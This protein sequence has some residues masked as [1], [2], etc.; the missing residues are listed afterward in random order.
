MAKR[1]LLFVFAYDVRKDS[2]RRK[3]S[4]RLERDL[5]RVQLSVFEGRMTKPEAE[6]LSLEVLALLD[7]GDSLR[8]YA[9]TPV[10]LKNTFTHGG[11]PVSE[12]EGYWLV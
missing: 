7:E 8:V 10:G 5:A 4:D 12:P 9:I 3:V 6:E 1:E 2:V 11:A